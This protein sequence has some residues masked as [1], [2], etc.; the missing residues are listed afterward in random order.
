MKKVSD[1]LND[2]LNSEK[3][4]I[5]TD[6]YAL[7]LR[8]G[9]TFYITDSDQDI[10]WNGHMW[11]HNM[12]LISRDQIKL[13]GTPTVDTL[14]VNI[15]CGI[16]D[17]LGDLPFMLSCHNGIL[18]GA[19]MGL[20]KAYFNDEGFVGAFKIFEGIVEVS[21]A[22]GLGVKLSVK[23]V[24]QGLA[25]SVPIR[26]FAPQSAYTN[27][28]GTVTTSSADTYSMLVPLKPSSNVVVKL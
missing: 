12:F 13:Q 18:E 28:N 3:H 6:M 25:Q 23:S 11:R 8:D 27:N 16:N 4:F 1:E 15:K 22:G 14:S 17:M 7:R 2:Y 20:F 24:V 26:V 19:I 21:S 5:V 10:D 9:Q